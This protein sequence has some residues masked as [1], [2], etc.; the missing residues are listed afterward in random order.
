[1]ADP[2]RIPADGMTRVLTQIFHSAGAPDAEA[3]GVASNLVEANLAGHDSHGVVRT[4]RYVEGAREGWAV[5][6]KTVETVLDAPCFALLEGGAGFGQ[7]IGPQAV[8]IGVKKAKSEGISIVALRNSAHLGRIGA[9]AEQAL[10]DGLV[11]IHFVNVS[12]SPLVAPFGAAARRAATNPVV[13]GVPGKD[14]D[15]FVLDF[16]TSRIAEGKALVALKAE[17]PVTYG[18][19]VD[20]AGQ[21]SDDPSVLYGDSA[22]DQAPNPRQGPGALVA[23]GDHKGSGL[24]LAC[25]LLAGAL[26]GN[27]TSGSE[28]G[29]GLRVLN[30]MLS[31]YLDPTK[32]D[33]GHGFGATVQEYIAQIREAPPADPAKPVM[34]PG[35]PERRARADRSANGLPLDPET[36]SNILTAGESVGLTRAALE[37]EAFA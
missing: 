23:M 13:I 37:A 30:G 24:S 12:G 6:E 10:S 21:L 34:I 8:D 3:Y 7:T 33:D 14:G 5:F 16:A 35:D 22:G 28:N 9:F 2:I 4:P 25:E 18:D 19:V 1:M 26:T 31:I 20:G 29:P 17:K 15:D 11:S 32:F 36:W 27:G